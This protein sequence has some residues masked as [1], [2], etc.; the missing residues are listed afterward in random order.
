MQTCLSKSAKFQSTTGKASKT[1]TLSVGV[2]LFRGRARPSLDSGHCQWPTC[3]L[4]VSQPRKTETMHIIW[5][6]VKILIVFLVL[7]LV[8]VQLNNWL[9][10]IW[11]RPYIW[12][13]SVAILGFLFVIGLSDLADAGNVIAWAGIMGFFSMFPPSLKSKAAQKEANRMIDQEYAEMGMPNGRKL[14]WTGIF[15]FLLGMAIGWI[16]S[17]GEIYRPAN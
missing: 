5:L 17:F 1:P 15:L 2:A 14:Y 16:L 11:R 7:K 8:L 12:L 10:T 3:F 9:F 6:I 13:V 4:W